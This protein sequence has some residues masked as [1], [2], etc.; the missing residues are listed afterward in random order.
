MSFLTE[1]TRAD[2]REAAVDA[3]NESAEIPVATDAGSGL[4]AFF[5][6]TSLIAVM[7]QRQL[8][9]VAAIARLSTIPANA[10]GTPNPDVDSYISPF[11][12][13]RL[14]EQYAKGPCNIGSPSNVVTQQ[15]VLVGVTLLGGGLIYTV[16]ADTSNTAYSAVLGGY[17]INPGYNTVSCT[18][19]C[20]VPGIIGNAQIGQINQLYNGPGSVA[21][22]AGI[23]IVSNPSAFN[24]GAPYESDAQYIARF[25]ARMKTGQGGTLWAMASALLGIAPGV[26]WAI[27]DCKDGVGGAKSSYFTVILAMLG[28]TGATSSTLLAQGV[29]ALEGNP[30]AI[31]PTRPAGISYQV[32]SPAILTVNAAATIKL[33][34][35]A[36]GSVVQANCNTAVA[37]YIAGLGLPGL[38]PATILP[39]L[40]VAAILYS[41][42]GV[43]QVDSL[44]LTQGATTSTGADLTAAYYQMFAAGTMTFTTTS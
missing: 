23:S 20:S 12:G 6:G 5:D 22:P 40:K 10:D 8:I 30:P 42:P 14:G 3:Y 7:E 27:A 17:P 36:V 21:P 41:V 11:I 9:Y 43:A 25:T 26:T 1:Y 38:L 2:F 32:I 18:V 34:P 31:L 35:G 16:V 29:L 24:T 44:V 19:Q 37:E 28:A 13:P 15:V 39:Y 4:G 33:T